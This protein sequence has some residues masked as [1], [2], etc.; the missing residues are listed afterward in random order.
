MKHRKI[1]KAQRITIEDFSVKYRFR[2]YE[3]VKDYNEKLSKGIPPDEQS[4]IRDIPIDNRLYYPRNWQIHRRGPK[5][6]MT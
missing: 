1:I 6:N 3:R 5:T 2:N 4:D